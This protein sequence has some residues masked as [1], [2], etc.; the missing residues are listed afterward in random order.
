MVWNLNWRVGR[1][2]PYG[3]VI[4]QLGLD[5]RDPPAVAAILLPDRPAPAP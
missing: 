2:E 5:E 1:Y 4:S 3:P